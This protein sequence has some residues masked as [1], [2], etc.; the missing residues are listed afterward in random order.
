MP[1]P[2][3]RS[4]RQISFSGLEV[5]SNKEISTFVFIQVGIAKHIDENH[6]YKIFYLY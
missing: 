5:K 3:S 6:D 4:I 1:S 2:S